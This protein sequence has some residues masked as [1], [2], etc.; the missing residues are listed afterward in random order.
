MSADQRLSQSRARTAATDDVFETRSAEI[1]RCRLPAAS[2]L[3]S[4]ALHRARRRAM[5]SAVRPARACPI[6]VSGSSSNSVIHA[7][8]WLP[9][10][11]KA[12]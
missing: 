9:F 11:I 4:S 2:S 7:L 6:A 8:E 5:S 1:S 12:G 10:G 3:S